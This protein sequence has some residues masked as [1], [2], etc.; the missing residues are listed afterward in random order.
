MH[1][2]SQSHGN[3]G[4]I[5]LFATRPSSR[6]RSRSS[7]S[8]GAVGSASFPLKAFSTL[9]TKGSLSEVGSK[10]RGAMK[11]RGQLRRRQSEHDQ[12]AAAKAYDDSEDEKDA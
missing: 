2:V 9:D 12:R 3:L 7:S 8:G 11:E 6:D 4:N 5:G 1:Q 10:I